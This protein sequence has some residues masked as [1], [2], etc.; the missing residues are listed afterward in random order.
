MIVKGLVKKLR[1]Q[2]QCGCTR[3]FGVR[4]ISPVLKILLAGLLLF[5]SVPLTIAK[6]KSRHVFMLFSRLNRD[7]LPFSDLVEST[8]RPRI[9]DSW[10]DW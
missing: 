10:G 9:G 5:L 4:G 2:A 6:D 8:L 7:D 1:I 3:R